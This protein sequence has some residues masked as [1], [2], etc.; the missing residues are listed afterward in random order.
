[1]SQ[2]RATARWSLY[3][4]TWAR[5]TQEPALSTQSAVTTEFVAW[6]GCFAESFSDEEL[7]AIAASVAEIVEIERNLGMGQQPLPLD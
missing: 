1:M 4:R 2:I 5:L 6:A 7:D 3:R